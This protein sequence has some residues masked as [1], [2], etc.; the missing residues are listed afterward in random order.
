MHSSHFFIWMWWS[1]DTSGGKQTN[2]QKWPAFSYFFLPQKFP[3][4]NSYPE[5]CLIELSVEKSANGSIRFRWNKL[6]K[7]Y[8][9]GNNSF[10]VSIFRWIFCLGIRIRTR[11]A[12]WKIC[13]FLTNWNDDVLIMVLFNFPVV[14]IIRNLHLFRLF[15]WNFSYLLKF[16]NWN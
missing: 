12:I 9:I 6:F 8:T 14:Y 2:E 10:F 5:E 11:K 16:L 1:I 3:E 4:A 15:H 13:F 7:V